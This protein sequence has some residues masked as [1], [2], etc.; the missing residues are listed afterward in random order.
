[1]GFLYSNCFSQLIVLGI[2]IPFKY[3]FIY[4]FVSPCS[5]KV[6]ATFNYVLCDL[7]YLPNEGSCR[8]VDTMMSMSFGFGGY[9]AACL[10]RKCDAN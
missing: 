8:Q 2:R 4:Y 1:V 10:I 6:T 7:N 3:C 5:K 9:N